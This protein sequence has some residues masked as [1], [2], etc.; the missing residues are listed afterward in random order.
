LKDF[1]YYFNILKKDISKICLGLNKGTGS[2]IEYKDLFQEASIKLFYLYNGNIP[3]I[4]NYL[5]TAIKHHLID[6][7]R[8]NSRKSPVK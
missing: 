8:K 3:P 6:Y 4:K 7:I 5:L 2:E 1:E